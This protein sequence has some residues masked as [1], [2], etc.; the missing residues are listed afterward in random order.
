MNET[1]LRFYVDDSIIYQF[2]FGDF[3][4]TTKYHSPFRV[5]PGPSFKFMN[6]GTSSSPKILW[7]DF[8]LDGVSY[9][10]GIGF[11]MQLYG[12]SRYDAVVKIWKEIV[13]GDKPIIP[14]K[15]SYPIKV[16]YEYTVQKFKDYDL[17][18]WSRLFLYEQFLKFFRVSSL[19]SLRRVGKRIWG[20]EESNPV[21]IYEF[22]KKGA[23]KVYR[24]LDKNNQKFRG[25]NNGDVLEGYD[26]LPARGTHLIITKSMKDVM[27]LRRMGYLAIAPTSE[28]SRKTLLNKAAELNQR[29]DKIYILFDNDKPGVIASHKLHLE[30]GWEQISFPVWMTKDSSDLVNK[31][32]NYFE[33]TEFFNTFDLNEYHI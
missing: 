1:R 2:Y 12:L 29:F 22:S 8:G 17:E 5:D 10:D 32:Q 3:D 23:F 7:K 20:S 25:Q 21:F 28:N 9:P 13:E 4:L 18:Y 19:R 30:T 6:V 15:I 16:P 11:V 26:Q 24:P 14:P 33:L 27:V 31:C